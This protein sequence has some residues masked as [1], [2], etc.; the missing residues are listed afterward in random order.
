MTSSSS[1]YWVHQFDEP[2]FLSWPEVK[3]GGVLLSSRYAMHRSIGVDGA[4]YSEVVT[5]DSGGK[6][7]TFQNNRNM[8]TVLGHHSE[9]S[10]LSLP[11]HRGTVDIRSFPTCNS[12]GLRNSEVHR[13]VSKRPPCMHPHRGCVVTSRLTGFIQSTVPSTMQEDDTFW[14]AS[15][16]RLLDQRVLDHHCTRRISVLSQ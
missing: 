5:Q 1:V 9:R 13:A 14:A 12:E 15:D 11:G 8:L 6:H 2:G 3:R 7:G 10:R 4:G 16:T